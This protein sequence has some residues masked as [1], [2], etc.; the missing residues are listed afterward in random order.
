M[1]AVDKHLFSLKLSIAHVS[2]FLHQ[3]NVQCC[4][5]QAVLDIVLSLR[6]LHFYSTEIIVFV[7]TTALVILVSIH[8]KTVLSLIILNHFMAA[9][10]G[11][12]AALCCLK[13]KGK[14]RKQK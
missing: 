1:I 2:L 11:R 7:L 12:N 5:S 9:S 3:V 8:L 13:C 4:E 6:R 14:M 10:R